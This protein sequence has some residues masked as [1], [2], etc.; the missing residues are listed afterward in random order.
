MDSYPGQQPN[1]PS[2]DALYALEHPRPQLEPA[3]GPQEVEVRRTGLH[4]ERGFWNTCL[5]TLEA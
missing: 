5:F 2:G 4:F 3:L 1:V